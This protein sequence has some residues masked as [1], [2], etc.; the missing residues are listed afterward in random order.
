VTSGLSEKSCQAAIIMKS[1]ALRG[2]A[3]DRSRIY[4]IRLMRIGKLHQKAS[5]ST[6]SK[7]KRCDKHH[8]L[9]NKRE[10]SPSDHTGELG[11]V[12]RI[13][14][15]QVT[16]SVNHGEDDRGRRMPSCAS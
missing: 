13:D 1:M 15:G 14:G 3:D 12:E 4:G 2:K 7:A 9:R 16:V 11:F 5:K 6:A 10:A 8:Q